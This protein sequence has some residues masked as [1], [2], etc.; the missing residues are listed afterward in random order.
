LAAAQP[1]L[2]MLAAAVALGV[3]AISA[4]PVALAAGPPVTLILTPNPGSTTA[5]QSEDYTVTAYEANG[6]DAYSRSFDV[7]GST[8]LT[9]APDGSCTANAC[10][11]T[12]AGPH[13]VTGT[14]TYEAN[15]DTGTATGTASLDVQ[16]GPPV[17]LTLAPNPGSITA[18]ASQDYQ[19]TGKDAY[20]NSFDVTGSTT[21]TIADGTCTGGT[22][23]PAPDGSCAAHT[24]T[25]TGAGAHTV[26]GTYNPGGGVTAAPDGNTTGAVTGTASLD[27][28]PGAPATLTLAPNPG[29]ITPGASQDYQASGK[30]AYGNPAGDLTGYTAFTIAPDGSCTAHTCTATTA[31]QHAVTGTVNLGHGA[32]ARGTASLD[33]RPGAPATLTLAPNPGSITAGASQDYQASG[34]DAY[35]NPLGDLTSSAT[36]TIAPDG[37]CTAHTCTATTAGPHTVTGTIDLGDGVTAHGTATL[38]VKPGPPTALALH[39]GQATIT[40]GDAITYQVAGGDAYGNPAGDLT[41]SATFTITPDGSCTA[42][43]CTATTAGPHTVTGI[44]SLGDGV[45]ARGTATLQVNPGPP[46][47]L[48]LHPGQV[49]ITAGEKQVY[50]ADGQDAYGNPLRDLTRY[51]TFTITPDG[52]CTAS[53]CTATTVGR[54]TVTGMVPLGHGVTARG[55]ATLQVNPGPAAT[56]TLHPGQATITA[57]EAIT[58]QADGE[59]AYGNPVGDLTSSAT[60]AITPDGSCTAST[61]T[62]TTAGPHTVTGAIDLR[63]HLAAGAATLQVQRKIAGGGPGPSSSSPSP[64]SDSSPP[65]PAPSSSSNTGPPPPAPSSGSGP[66]PP[67]PSPPSSTGPPPPPPSGRVTKSPNCRPAAKQLRGLRVA[68]RSAPPGTVVRITATID[69]NFAGCPL[70]VLLGGSHVGDTTVGR[71]GSVS[72]RSAVPG[73]AKSG[74]TTLALARTDGGV[75][76]T[77]AFEVVPKPPPT[78][79]LLQPLLALLVTGGA[80]LLTGLGGKVVASERAR[81][82]R[83][84]VGKHVR[85]EPDSS[86]G[87]IAAAPDSHAPP[88]LTVRLKTHD[89]AGAIGITKESDR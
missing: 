18:G 36:F 62:A 68:P 43:T 82:Q 54:H 26:T 76:A 15:G 44:V 75:L 49:T 89:H 4:A 11:A 46:A 60:F 13:T 27:V 69:R 88:P 74:I 83:R 47:T 84:W 25:A 66:A 1:I 23:T 65:P 61:C 39:P 22:C 48:T 14:I 19:A 72:D 86:P 67:A 9:I 3:V 29:S 6:Q 42:H 64:S 45:T 41:S 7:T 32:T 30:D 5:G 58:Y 28:R 38:Q 34:K 2:F 8:I 31:G 81:R 24:C 57:G 20:G 70:A 80:L 37:S 55:T 12:T 51:T 52:S 50:R 71:D 40:A 59:D 33:V 78:P 73:A 56:L 79:R 16:P 17:T 77:T 87:H 35:G 53:T 85:V 21:F 10:T 63:E